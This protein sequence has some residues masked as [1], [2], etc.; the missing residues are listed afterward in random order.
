MEE[1]P[2]AFLNISF[3]TKAAVFPGSV[4]TFRYRLARSGWPGKPGAEIQAWVYENTCFELA[5]NT[6]TETFPWTEEGIAALR[7]WLEA[8][9]RERG[10]EPYRIPFPPGRTPGETQREEHTARS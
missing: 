1:G 5:R 3:L 7:G 8:K 4:G 10:A 2:F 9:L 6:E